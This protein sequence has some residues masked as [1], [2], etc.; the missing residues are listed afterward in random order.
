MVSTDIEMQSPTRRSKPMKRMRTPDSDEP[1]DRP[2]KRVSTGTTESSPTPVAR[3]WPVADSNSRH[4]T[5][6][7]VAQARALRLNSPSVPCTPVEGPRDGDVPFRGQAGQDESMFVDTEENR[8][9][10]LS[11][12]TQSESHDPPLPSQPCLPPSNNPAP[13][14]SQQYQQPLPSLSVVS[15]MDPI[16]AA[17]D[18]QI[19]VESQ[20]M[21]GSHARSIPSADALAHSKRQR[22]TMGPRADCEKCRLGV[23]GHSVHFD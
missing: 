9:S 4:P 6:E 3:A 2:N 20:Q 22:F 12:G 16:F 7:W 14:P 18:Q 15:Q 5:D 1:Y 21:Y 8:R 17:I 23:K 13:R 19:F 11:K 10:L